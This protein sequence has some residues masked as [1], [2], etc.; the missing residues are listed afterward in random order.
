MRLHF[1]GANRQ[2]T[3]SRY[4]LET[5]DLRVMIDCG[6]FQERSCLDRNWAPPIVAPE[7]VD[8]MLLT[9]AHLDHCGLIP[10]YVRQGFSQRIL[11]TA[12][13]ID[14]ATIVLND[15]ARIQEEDARYKRKRHE[16]EG[17]RGAHPELALYEVE[18]AEA[19]GPLFKV[20]QYDKPIQLGPGV[21]VSYRDAGHILGSAMLVFDVETSGQTRRVLFSG[22]VGPSNR[23]L[24]H[25]ATVIESADYV[26]VESTY[27][28]RNHDVEGDL[29]ERFAEFVNSTV[30]RGGNLIIPTFA[31]DRAQALVYY[32]GQL[33]R[34]KRIP[35]L[36]IFLDSPMA[37]D[38]T[39]IYKL[40][41][42]MLD[43]ET[44]QMM[45]RGDHP[46][47]YPGIQYVRNSHESKALN[48]IR[49][50]VIIMA[51]SGMCTGGRIKHHLRHNLSREECTVLFSGYQ[52]RDTLG[53]HIL[54]RPDEVRIHGRMYPVK[55]RIE[56]LQGLSAH[57]DQRGLLAWLGHLK[58]PRQVFLTHGEEDAANALREKVKEQFGWEA[59]IPAYQE[60]V[61]LT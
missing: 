3:G 47:Q 14:L 4:L 16:R 56:Q 41:E 28:D 53:R 21:T 8:L 5:A 12:P 24:V 7:S 10:R 48:F 11:A 31:I 17:R 34:Q 39:N 46:F 25:D 51:G 44:Q 38:A 57:A 22:D 35:R 36:P 20:V 60:T 30:E 42:H 1:L 33:V 15:S 32:L 26:I 19:V 45:D 2:V 13:T 37:I 59:K 49:G 54:E 23:P 55:A 6:M 58:Q 50:S 43:E 18:D 52:S 9:H 61:E 40:Y 27:G 29:L